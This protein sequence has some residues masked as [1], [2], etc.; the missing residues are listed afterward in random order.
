[1]HVCAGEDARLLSIGEALEPLFAKTPPPP[2]VAQCAGCRPAVK[3]VDVTWDGVGQPKPDDVTSVYELVLHGD[4]A[5]KQAPAR[6]LGT[7]HGSEL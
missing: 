2:E 3:V 7:A 1:M 6:P 5:L 4:C